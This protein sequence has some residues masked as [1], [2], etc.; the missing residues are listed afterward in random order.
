M[1][2]GKGGFGFRDG[3]MLPVILT[4]LDGRSAG[5]RLQTIALDG[6][7][8]ACCKAL[9]AYARMTNEKPVVQTFLGARS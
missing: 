5:Q 2:I 8:F 6:Q 9:S 7:T 1:G 3:L 4:T